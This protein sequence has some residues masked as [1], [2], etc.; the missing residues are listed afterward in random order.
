MKGPLVPLLLLTIVCAVCLLIGV[1]WFVSSSSEDVVIASARV[2][3]PYQRDRL[4]DSDDAV[5]EAESGESTISNTASVTDY[6]GNT[7]RNVSEGMSTANTQTITGGGTASV[8][9]ATAKAKS[10][11][12]ELAVSGFMLGRDEIHAREAARRQKLIDLGILS[13][14]LPP[15]PTIA[16]DVSLDMPERCKGADIARVPIGVKFRFESS[17]IKGESLNALE[18]LVAFYRECESGQFILAQNPLGRADATEMLMQMRFDEIKYF[19][20]QHSVSI[21]AVQFS[22]E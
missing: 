2:S 22:E 11:E 8:N 12:A 15:E 5:T 17:L 18:S 21:D 19:F 9:A 3:S 13:Q 7:S 14:T 16:I 10:E 20:I 4:Q 1:T 6:A